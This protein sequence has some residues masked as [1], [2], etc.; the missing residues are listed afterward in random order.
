[1]TV[2]PAIVLFLTIL[3]WK[4]NNYSVKWRCIIVFLHATQIPKII[5]FCQ[6]T[7]NGQ[8]WNSWCPILHLQLLEGE[9][10]SC[11]STSQ[12]IC[13]FCG[14]YTNYIYEVLWIKV[15]KSS[16][17]SLFTCIGQHRKPWLYLYHSFKSVFPTIVVWNFL[18]QKNNHVIMLGISD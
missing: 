3:T 7:K 2:L 17:S 11:Y 14:L 6:Y 1:M 18:N 13:Y 5:Y 12:S 4:L 15:I 8:K 10:Y 16:E 9:Q